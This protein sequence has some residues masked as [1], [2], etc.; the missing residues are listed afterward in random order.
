MR[1]RLLMIFAVLAQDATAEH[2]RHRTRIQAE[3]REV[4]L[5]T[6]ISRGSCLEQQMKVDKQ[7]M[8][9]TESLDA[10]GQ[11]FS[12]VCLACGARKEF[13][14]PMSAIMR[15]VHCPTCGSTCVFF[16][17]ELEDGNQRGRGCG[18]AR[19]QREGNGLS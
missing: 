15:D 2:G 13:D 3:P 19:C 7:Q 10:T 14:S 4:D 12:I 8:S 1:A 18:R 11:V 5:A 16:Y 9:S 6:M 17:Y